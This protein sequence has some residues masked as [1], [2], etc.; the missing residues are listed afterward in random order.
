M[1]PTM[2]A[3]DPGFPAGCQPMMWVLFG[4]KHMLKQENWVPLGGRGKGA[5]Q[6]CPL[7]LPLN[8][9]YPN[10]YPTLSHPA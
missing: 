7:D 10:M 6:W 8:V 9:A 3:A 2:S 1:Y 4:G 5:H